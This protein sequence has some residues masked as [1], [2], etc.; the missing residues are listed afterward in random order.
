MKFSKKSFQEKY[1]PRKPKELEEDVIGGG[2]DKVNTHSQVSVKTPGT[3]VPQEPKTMD[4][5]IGQ[6][7][8]PSAIFGYGE[9]GIPYGGRQGNLYVDGGE[10]NY[11]DVNDTTINPE[12]EED[13]DEI[14]ESSKD[15]MRRMVKELMDSRND[16]SELVSKGNDVILKNKT[17]ELIKILKNESP[18][19]V[20]DVINQIKIELDKKENNKPNL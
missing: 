12:D 3:N 14:T 16:T 9:M 1:K 5:H 19:V 13:S 6:V 7:R 20:Q 15:I 18:E 2:G 17:N 10:E 11:L 4:Q 8:N